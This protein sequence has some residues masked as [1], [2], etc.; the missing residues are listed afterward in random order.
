[1]AARVIFVL[2]FS[3]AVFIIQI[4][5]LLFICQIVF[6]FFPKTLAAIGNHTLP[7]AYV[8]AFPLEIATM[9]VLVGVSAFPFVAVPAVLNLDGLVFLFYAT[10]DELSTHFRRVYR[11]SAW[12]FA[13]SHVIS[14]MQSIAVSIKILAC[15][16]TIALP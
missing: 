3:V 2:L 1:M 8:N 6:L 7:R 5:H 15:S 13:R 4:Y 12:S 9:I 10:G 11:L 14:F 16:A